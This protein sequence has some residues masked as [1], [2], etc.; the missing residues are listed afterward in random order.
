MAQEFD[1]GAPIQEQP[2]QITAAQIF[3]G[4]TM[5]SQFASAL[6]KF[7][8]SNLGIIFK[9]GTTTQSSSPAGKLTFAHNL[10]IVPNFYSISSQA[11][12]GAGPTVNDFYI[13]PA[14]PPDATNFYLINS[15]GIAASIS[16]SWFV[17]Y[18]PKQ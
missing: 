18:I 14:N 7:I 2:G 4:Q 9:N 17:A 5:G 12:Q 16:F 15:S 3:D 6:R 8:V 11:W 1:S 13:D 10:G